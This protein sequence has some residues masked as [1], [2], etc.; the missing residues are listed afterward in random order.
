MV[1]PICSYAKAT[2]AGGKSLDE[3]L[4]DLQNGVTK[5]EDYPP[6]RVVFHKEC[7]HT[8]DNRRLWLFKKFGEEIIVRIQS[9]VEKEFF[10]KL[11]ASSGGHSV[12]FVN[13]TEDG[14]VKSMSR[15]LE[16]SVLSWTAT[17]IMNPFL[18]VKH[19]CTFSH[20]TFTHR[21][22]PPTT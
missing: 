6:I 8:L 19:V 4:K 20:F 2:R 15:T 1:L 16:A 7:Y 13:P 9:T 11:F 5:V 17:N 21:S 3:A 18:H 12:E 10:Q 22:V 14:K